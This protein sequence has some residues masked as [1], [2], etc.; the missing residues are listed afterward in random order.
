MVVVLARP[1]QVAH[2]EPVDEHGDLARCVQERLGERMAFECER[3]SL[4]A[5]AH[6][7]G[8]RI[9]GFSKMVADD[10]VERGERNFPPA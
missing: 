6:C 5:K 4:V 3:T 8:E 10:A 2:A 7:E 9:A 1:L